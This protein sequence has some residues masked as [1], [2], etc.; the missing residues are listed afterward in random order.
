[1]LINTFFPILS[2]LVQPLSGQC[3]GRREVLDQVGF[4]SGYGVE[5]GLLI[6]ISE[7]FGLPVIGQ[8]DLMELIHRNRELSDL[9]E[10][11]FAIVQVACI[12]WRGEASC[13]S[14]KKSAR[15]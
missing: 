10:M 5:I 3:A 12:G 9:S 1:M 14:S 6:D 2:G 8:V 4:Y 11:S 15:V 7:K 13:T